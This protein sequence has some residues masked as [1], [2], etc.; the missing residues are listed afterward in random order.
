MPL[1]LLLVYSLTLLGTIGGLV[2]P[3]VAFLI[4]VAFGIMKPEV[5]WFGSVPPGNYSRY[6]AVGLLIGWVIRLCG[7]W[8]FGRA[9]GPILALLFFLGWAQLGGLFARNQVVA[10]EFLD[11][12]TKI[13]IPCFVGLTLIDSV[14]KLK[15]LAW[16]I[17]LSIGYVAFHENEAYFRNP[18]VPRD[19]VI[20]HTMALGIS[21]GFFLGLYSSHWWQSIIAFLC[22]ALMVH[23]I[24]IHNSRGAMLGV[25]VLGMFTFILMEK[26]PGHYWMFFLGLVAAFMMAGPA[27]QERFMTI[28]AS[29]EQRDASAESRLQFW[30]GMVRGIRAHPV[31]GVGPDHWHLVSDEYGLPPHR[32]G[33][34]LWLQVTAEHGLPAVAALVTFYLLTVKRLLPL[35]RRKEKPADPWLGLLACT[36]LATILGFMAEAVF[37]SF[38]T[39]EAAYY[40]AI[41]GSGALMMQDRLKAAAAPS[42]VAPAFEPPPA[43]AGNLVPTHLS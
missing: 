36:C 16:V 18:A 10:Q 31:F 7:N 34:N 30:A 15:Q 25:L 20:A 41:L 6:V 12:M 26:K 37:G 9:R 33:H 43:V 42:H 1:S 23:G 4:Y 2:A 3:Y 19:N 39:L 17:T 27:V 14:A 32:E 40:V 35:A 5:V 21:I 29:E 11:S 8:N 24:T 28:F 38:R 13:I 22:S